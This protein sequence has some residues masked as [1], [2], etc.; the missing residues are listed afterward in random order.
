[1]AG[2]APTIL[3]MRRYGSTTDLVQS[4]AHVSKLTGK[5]AVR[6]MAEAAI[7]A[8]GPGRLTVSD[9]YDFG[10]WRPALSGSERAEFISESQGTNLN[11]RLSPPGQ[12]NL[13]GLVRSKLL[14]GL[15]LRAAGLPAQLPKALFGVAYELPGVVRLS[16]PSQI[17]SWLRSDG[18]LP[19]FGKPVHQSLCIGVAS[20]LS[21][22]DQGKAV[23]LGDGRIA[24]IDV[25]AEEISTH[26]SSGYLFEPLIRQHPEVEAVTG[27]AVG[28]LRVVTLR[29]PDGLRV[30]YLAQRLPAVGSMHDGVL[31]SAPFA[32]AWVDMET[33][34]YLRVQ[35]MSQLAPDSL[36]RSHVTGKAFAEVTLPFVREALDVAIKAHEVIGVPGIL[37]FDIAL[38]EHG[39][40]INEINGN[41]NHSIYQRSRDRGLLNPDIKPRI[42]AAIA[43]ARQRTR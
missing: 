19:V 15:V 3:K 41:P 21:L 28:A 6:Q 36:M 43:L 30:L 5:G 40:L 42:L 14:T 24:P 1:M 32:E 18:T 31:P 23:L 9:Y 29:E 12:G 37:G 20:Y 2:T 33:G 22:L 35:D 10:I 13:S 26:F 16:G 27:R 11:T 38:S 8:L 4:M 17:A 7:A 34:R 25:L 39:P